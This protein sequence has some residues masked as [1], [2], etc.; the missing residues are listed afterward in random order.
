MRIRTLLAALALCG[1]LTSAGQAYYSFVPPGYDL[2]D[3]PHEKYFQW[4]IN[5][6]VPTGEAIVSASLTFRNIYNWTEEDN[7]RLWVH[8]LQGAPAGVTSGNDNQ[9]Y[10][11]WFQPPQYLGENI[12]LN[13]FDNLP[14]GEDDAQ[15]IIYNFDSIEIQALNSYAADGNF[16]LGFDPDC[17]YY[18]DKVRLKI[19]T[20]VSPI[21]EPGTIILLGLGLTGVAGLRRRRGNKA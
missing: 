5:W 10:G 14:E 9:A 2:Q 11:S 15:T 7:D 19:N 18:N 4:G 6:S 20:A 13:E 17:H 16:G 8:L 12:L 21:P 3:L 1:A